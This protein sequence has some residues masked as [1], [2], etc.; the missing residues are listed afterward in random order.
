M[1]P[2][3]YI[4]FVSVLACLAAIAFVIRGWKRTG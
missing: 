2:V 1:H 3:A 4:E